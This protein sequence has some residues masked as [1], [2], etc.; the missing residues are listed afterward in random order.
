MIRT[1][2]MIS[3]QSYFNPGMKIPGAVSYGSQ[4]GEKEIKDEKKI[5]EIDNLL[6]KVKGIT[7]YT[8]SNQGPMVICNKPDEK[9]IIFVSR[10]VKVKKINNKMTSVQ[11][12]AKQTLDAIWWNEKL[13][14][15]TNR[16]LEKFNMSVSGGP[17]AKTI[18]FDSESK[19]ICCFIEYHGTGQTIVEVSKGRLEGRP[20]KPAEIGIIKAKVAEISKAT[21][22]IILKLISE[23]INSK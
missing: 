9:Y 19:H 8:D 5:S 6:S 20:A 18:M 23:I 13:I 22:D 12:T 16:V 21:D 2:N 7:C 14:N 10:K 17:K 3:S 1:G 4:A 11:L 15:D